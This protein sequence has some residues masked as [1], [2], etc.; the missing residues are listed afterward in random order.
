M[1]CKLLQYLSSLCFS[2]CGLLETDLLLFAFSQPMKILDKVSSDLFHTAK[3]K[4]NESIEQ[5]TESGV[6]EGGA[7]ACFFAKQR[8]KMGL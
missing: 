4:L 3:T 1:P 5:P 6:Q 2:K 7:N 8:L